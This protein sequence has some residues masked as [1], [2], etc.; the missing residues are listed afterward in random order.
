[1]RPGAVRAVVLACLLAVLAL[2]VGAAFAASPASAQT[3]ASA[4]VR[5]VVVVG[6]SGLR[7]S[8]VSPSATPTLWRLAGQG[9][10]GSL[11]DYA[12]L[13]LTCPADAWLTL[14]AGARAQSDHTN[15]ACGAF[16]AVNPA[17]TGAVVPALGTLEAYNNRFHN[18]PSWGLLAQQA[19]GCATAVGPGAALA[20]ADK[21]GHVASY[22]PS[23]AGLTAGVL[24][25]CPL[26]VVD[27]GNLGYAERSSALASMDAELAHIVADRPAGSTL[28][29]TA[30]GATTKPP[31][32]QLALISGPGYRPAC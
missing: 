18:N 11:V 24:A 13:P 22:L 14:N 19:P 17:G 12:V 32:L 23:A 29:V 2:G 27:L 9:S 8:D 3:R 6:I 28:L 10:V 21:S 31:H 15:A 7:W 20:L 25:R 5:H 4:P 30:P 26:T 1:M 16:P